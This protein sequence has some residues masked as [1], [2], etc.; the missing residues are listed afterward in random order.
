MKTIKKTLI[1]FNTVIL[2]IAFISLSFNVES[3]KS[4]ETI[5]ALSN[6]TTV[7]KFQPDLSN[8][9]LA[10]NA[11]ILANNSIQASEIA[12]NTEI[13]NYSS[14]YI[15]EESFEQELTIEYW[16]LEPFQT[17]TQEITD[18]TTSTTCNEEII[19]E[20]ELYIESWMINPS[21]WK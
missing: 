9:I 21:E 5:A 6:H 13:S 7:Y 15:T 3:Q 8:L 11:G 18:N 17:A 1:K 14:A 12:L 4:T 16:M 2:F 19:I 20:D 10:I